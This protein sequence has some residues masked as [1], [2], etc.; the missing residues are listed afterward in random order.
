MWDKVLK[1]I[2]V[3]LLSSVK[4]VGGVPLSFAYGFGYVETILFTVTG[5]MTGVLVVIYGTVYITRFTIWINKTWLH[6]SREKEQVTLASVPMVKVKSL[7]RKRRIRRFIRLWKKYG[8]IGIALIT[9]I[10][11]SIPVGTFL[12]TRLVASKR[13]VFFYMFGSVLF[14]S[15]FIA[16]LFQIYQVVSL[17]ELYQDIK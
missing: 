2:T 11:I 10:L 5:G 12:A 15:V 7:G 4:F 8:L 9:P 1:V 14:W 6:L 17:N 3:V 16:T 13:K